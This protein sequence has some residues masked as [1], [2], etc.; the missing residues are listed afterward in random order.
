MLRKTPETNFHLKLIP[1][2][3]CLTH[4]RRSSLVCSSENTER[5]F[6]FSNAQRSTKYRKR[7]KETEKNMAYIIEE[8]NNSNHLLDKDLKPTV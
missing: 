5:W 1:R 7:Y 6:F 8:E 3:R 2:L 4:Q